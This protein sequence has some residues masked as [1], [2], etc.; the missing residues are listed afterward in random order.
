MIEQPFDSTVEGKVITDISYVK[1]ESSR[2][3]FEYGDKED[4]EKAAQG[5]S[6]SID[7]IHF[8][9]KEDAIMDNPYVNQ[10]G[11]MDMFEYGD[12]GDIKKAAQ[13]T[14][15]WP[16]KIQITQEDEKTAQ[17][18]PGWLGKFQPT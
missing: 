11:I 1:E 4:I 16:D 18:E 10:E 6:N 5:A 2:E 13:E 12:K 9:R 15:D 17:G 14:S 7:E 8:T 3:M